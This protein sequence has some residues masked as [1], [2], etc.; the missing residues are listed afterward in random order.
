MVERNYETALKHTFRYCGVLVLVQ[1]LPQLKVVLGGWL[2][3]DEVDVRV[4]GRREAHDKPDHGK[5]TAHAQQD[6]FDLGRWL[7]C[8]GL[9]V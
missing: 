1:M 7:S 4:T 3:S 8:H 9:S 2:H 5:Q 6:A